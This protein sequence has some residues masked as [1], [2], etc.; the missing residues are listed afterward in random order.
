L[1]ARPAI[2]PSF[3]VQRSVRKVEKGS[4]ADETSGQVFHS[5]VKSAAIPARQRI[6]LRAYVDL[7]LRRIFIL[8]SQIQMCH[9][10]F[11]RFMNSAYTAMCIS[12]IVVWPVYEKEEIKNSN[13]YPRD[14][15]KR[16]KDRLQPARIIMIFN[17]F[18]TG[19]HRDS[20]KLKF[21]STL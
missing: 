21:Q 3:S 7:F 14:T 13:A 1:N 16:P 20:D 6:K 12:Q 17:R 4:L 19:L 15:L 9:V 18:G 2:K 11:I 8:H 5:V 10:G